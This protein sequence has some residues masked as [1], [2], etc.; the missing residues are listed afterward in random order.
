MCAGT[1]E[2]RASTG[3]TEAPR[4][5]AAVLDFFSSARRRLAGAPARRGLV[6]VS[7][8]DPA[9]DALAERLR[10]WRRRLARAS[11][12]PPHVLLH[13]ATVLAIARRRPA[14]VEDLLTVPGLGPVK[15]ARYGPALLEVIANQTTADDDAALAAAL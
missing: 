12:V 6:D 1:H 7:S 2:Q 11:G 9:D 8:T 10:Q 13:D 14:T 3:P 4:P 5:G 15:V